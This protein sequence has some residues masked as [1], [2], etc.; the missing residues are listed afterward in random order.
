MSRH[1]TIALVTTA[2]IPFLVIAVCAG[3]LPGLLALPVMIMLVSLNATSVLYLE[4]TV[5]RL[6]EQIED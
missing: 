4:E 5:R 3:W 6:R 1:V 2:L